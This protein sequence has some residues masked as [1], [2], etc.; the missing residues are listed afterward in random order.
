MQEQMET[1]C[2]LP[3]GNQNGGDSRERCKEP[4]A[5]ERGW[6]IFLTSKRG[7]RRHYG[8]LEG[9]SHYLQGGGEE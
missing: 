3:L 4:M 1:R 2:V 5:D 6:I 7:Y 9:G 8:D